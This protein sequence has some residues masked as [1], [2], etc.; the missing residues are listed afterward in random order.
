MISDEKIEAALD[1]LAKSVDEAAQARADKVYLTEYRKTLKA[2]L[3]NQCNESTEGAKERFAYAH[4][5]YKTHLN[6][7]KE[8]VRRDAMHS[9]RREAYNAVIEAWRTQQ[10]NHRAMEKIV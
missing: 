3:M 1:Y 7:L 9:F 4:E 8:S 6:G 5:N 10:A 2:E